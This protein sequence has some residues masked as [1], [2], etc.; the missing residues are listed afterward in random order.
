MAL[1]LLDHLDCSFHQISKIKTEGKFGI[2]IGF[3]CIFCRYF[4]VPLPA[5]FSDLLHPFH[6][7]LTCVLVYAQWPRVGQPA[8]NLHCLVSRL[9]CHK[10]WL[11]AKVCGRVR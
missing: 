8:I 10:D 9:S 4:S 2:K 7:N 6:I 11:T 5:P 1:P 3:F